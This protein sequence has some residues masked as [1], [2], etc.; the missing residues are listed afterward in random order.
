MS[1]IIQKSF[2]GGEFSPFLYART[3]I[4][5]YQTAL[6]TC[7][8]FYVMRHGGATNRP[9]SQ[10]VC[11]V[12]DSSK[13]VRLIPFIFSQSQ[14]YTLEFGNLY[15]RVIKNGEQVRL[16]AQNITGITNANPAVLTYSGADTYANGNEVYISGLTGELGK[17]LNNRNFKVANVNTGANTFELQYLDGTN[18]NSTSMGA[19]VSG[20][21]IAE[22]FELTTT[23]L[24]ADLPDLKYAQSAD[25]MTIVHPSYPPRN[26]SRTGDT[27]W[28]IADIVF[29]SDLGKIDMGPGVAVQNGTTGS[30]TYD[31]LVTVV[32]SQ[33]GEESPQYY[34]STEYTFRA[35]NGN[36]TLTPTNNIS[37]SWEE[38][39]GSTLLFYE[40][41]IYKKVNGVYGY[42]GT[43]AGPANFLGIWNFTDTGALIPDTTDGPP[44]LLNPFEGSGNYPSTVNYYQQR[45]CFANTDT[46]IEKVITSK[47]GAFYNFSVTKPLQ[48]NDSVVFRMS[49]KQVNE[50]YHLVD[51]GVLLIFT[52]SGEHSAQGGADGVLTPTTINTRQSSYNG[53]SQRMAP[54]VIGNSAVYVQARGNNIRDINF[55]YESDNYTGNELSI[56]SSH[57]VDDY[58]LLDWAYQQI[59]HSL[60]WVV[61]DDGV[62]LSLTYVKEQEMLAWARH[63]F[64]GGIVENVCSIP[65]GTEDGLYLTIR[66]T[67]NGQS[68]RYI[69][70]LVS[71][72]IIDNKD[73]AILDS[74]LSYDGR[75]YG[76][77]TMTLSGSGWTYEDSLT[78]TASASFFTADD[79]GNQIQIYDTDGSV[80]RFTIEGYTSATVVTGKPHRTVPVSLQATATV[81]WVK[82]VDEINGLW[83]LEGK[84]VSIYADGLVAANPNNNAYTIVTVTNGRITLSEAYGVVYVGLPITADLETLNI[85]QNGLETISDRNKLIGKVTL[86]TEKS[87]G[88]WAGTRP[89]DETVDFLDGLTELKIR[90]G[91]NYD[92]PI[93]NVTD[94]VDIITEANWNNHGRVFIRQTD[95]VPV[96]I[97]AITPTGWIPFTGSGG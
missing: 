64:E 4:A 61:R 12:K 6:R 50:V 33:T 26:L 51:L 53:S 34:S 1:S 86:S 83:H 25:V 31:Y 58:T 60:L 65:D 39:F 9:G 89:P 23:Y 10:F 45:L 90:E 81:N 66:R 88:I 94:S 97:L 55:R 48:D 87:R 3:D 5:K 41:N 70:K 21:T 84:Q 17:N 71:R 47:T 62:L 28:S 13:A 75:N 59:P 79:I 93:S 68:K 73:I 38:L 96:T 22:V 37:L 92:S 29:E 40:F 80:I 36:A 11:E 19:Y 49:G 16:T 44:V 72:K 52:E 82:A 54:I 42:L 35:T 77:T 24:E 27:S 20:G 95:P 85:D 76:S 18:V 8:N 57:L 32:N 74:H 14:T 67:V 78:L 30:T 15:M 56:F 91:E 69:E 63:D 7:R 43:V 2:A 46:E